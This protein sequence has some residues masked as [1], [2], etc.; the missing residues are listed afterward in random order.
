MVPDKRKKAAEV[1]QRTV[2]QRAA[3]EFPDLAGGIQHRDQGTT[4]F[5]TT[6]YEDSLPQTHTG[7]YGHPE[8]SD[9]ARLKARRLRVC[10]IPSV[11]KPTATIR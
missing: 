3:G 6:K 11:G 4:M 9:V 2:D 1:G 5:R 7:F 8:T 10:S